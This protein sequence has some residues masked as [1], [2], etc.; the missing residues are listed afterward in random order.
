MGEVMR[1]F[2][3]GTGGSRFSALWGTGSTGGDRPPRAL[4]RRHALT[5]LI[6]AFTFVLPVAAS[7]STGMG[8]GSDYCTSS[9]CLATTTEEPTSEGTTT[10]EPTSEGTTT[11]EPTSDGTTTTT[12]EDAA[13]YDAAWYDAAWYDAAWS[14]DLAVANAGWYD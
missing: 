3:H 10:T 14:D 2:D 8:A 9:D 11:T 4:A 13:W 1:N 12:E 5:V 6:A 7:A